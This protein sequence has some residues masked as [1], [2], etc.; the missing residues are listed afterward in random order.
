APTGTGLR[1]DGAGRI[2]GVSTDRPGGDVEA[3]VVIACDGVHSFL[4]KQAGLYRNWSVSHFTVGVKEVLALP[5]E[6][7]EER[8]NLTGDEGLDI[9]ILGGTQGIPG[10]GF[11]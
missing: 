1:R 8:F 3:G 7:L 10:G 4:A 9:E 6:L 5:R 11:L 2:R